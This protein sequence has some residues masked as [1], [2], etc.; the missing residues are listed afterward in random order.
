M[1]ECLTIDCGC[2]PQTFGYHSSEPPVTVAF[3]DLLDMVTWTVR[4][5]TI[6]DG[7]F[8]VSD[9]P[10]PTAV[11]HVWL[12]DVLDG[13]IYK[14]QIFDGVDTLTFGNPGIETV[15]NAF[16]MIDQLTAVVYDVIIE[17]GVLKVTL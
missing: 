12:R 6:V 16:S 14:L 11:D 3:L 8:Q 10:L 17:D 15:N 1:P 2:P 5:I 4:R 7:E 13:T 9:S